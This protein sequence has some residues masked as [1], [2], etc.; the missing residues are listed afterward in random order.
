M[1]ERA[2]V[3][4]NVLVLVTQPFPNSWLASKFGLYCHERG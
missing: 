3:D 1:L 2:V 4:A